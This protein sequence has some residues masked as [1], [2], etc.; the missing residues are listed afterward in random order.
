M[1]LL[2]WRDNLN[3]LILDRDMT[4]CMLIHCSQDFHPA[5]LLSWLAAKGL[6]TVKW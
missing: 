2:V 5:V 6:G 3:D 1:F 4:E